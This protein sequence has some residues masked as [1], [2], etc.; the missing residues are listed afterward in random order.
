MRTTP[1]NALLVKMEETTL[2]LTR[3]KSLNY[4]SKLRSLNF[5]NPARSLL[6]ELG[7]SE[8][9]SV[10]HSMDK[11][12]QMKDLTKPQPYHPAA[13]DRLPTEAKSSHLYLNSAFNNTN[14]VK[15]T[16]QYQNIRIVYH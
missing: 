15:P 3:H 6:D 10:I 1:I 8:K 12:A 16:A 13:Q 7:V 14:C 9:W 5:R 11:R 2:K 4:W